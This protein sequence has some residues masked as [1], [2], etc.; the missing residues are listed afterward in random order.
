M[1]RKE[2]VPKSQHPVSELQAAACASEYRPLE[3]A[4]LALGG[5]SGRTCKGPI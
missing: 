4:L 3:A 1:K 5:A 2:E